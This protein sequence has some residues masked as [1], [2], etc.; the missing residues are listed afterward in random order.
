MDT[1][2]SD[3]LLY[4]GLVITPPKIQQLS[5]YIHKTLVLF[6]NSEKHKH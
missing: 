3:L 5:Y 1:N 2:K 4:I 6:L